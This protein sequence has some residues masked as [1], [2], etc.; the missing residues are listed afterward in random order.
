M[1]SLHTT[2]TL[3]IRFTIQLRLET[4]YHHVTSS[5]LTQE[6]HHHKHNVIP[7]PKILP[8]VTA[9]H[10]IFNQKYFQLVCSQILEV[11]DVK[12]RCKHKASSQPKDRH[13]LYHRDTT[14]HP[15]AA[16][17]SERD[18]LH[19]WAEQCNDPSASLGPCQRWGT[20]LVT[21]P[22]CSR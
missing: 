1:C 7:P 3:L 8:N 18:Q 21:Q 10:T 19:C 15:R 11:T 12:L 13:L 9:I 6:R 14:S 17:G 22:P 4:G 2:G 20:R 16:K 5:F